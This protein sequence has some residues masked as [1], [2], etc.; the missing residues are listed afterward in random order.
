MDQPE[1][2]PRQLNISD[3]PIRPADSQSPVPLYYQIS[4]DLRRMIEEH[5]IPPGSILPP[6]VEI[7]QA[8]GVG[9]QTIRQAIARL[10]DDNLID[11][12]AGRGTFVRDHAKRASFHLDRSFSQHV[13]ALGME[14]SS[15]TLCQEENTVANDAHPQLVASIGQPCLNLER[16]RYGDQEPICYQS[17][18]VLTQ[19]CP[20]VSAYDFNQKSLYEVLANDYGL[21]IA[22]IEHLIRAVAADDYRAELLEVDPGVPL[23]FVNTIAY[24]ENGEIIE[25]NLSHYRGDRYE[26]RT[27]EER[28]L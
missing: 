9:R 25:V 13:R 16:V 24:L 19:R 20:G 10:V 5:V 3:L 28:H 23:L 7:C 1:T 11:R 6:E 12:Y 18:T 2:T 15:K 22:R 21:I 26:Y 4:L 8:Y 14:P 17:T 27:A